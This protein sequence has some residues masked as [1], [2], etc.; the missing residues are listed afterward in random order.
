M[1][2]TV[3]IVGAGIVG[4]ALAQRLAAHDWDV[5]V[6]DQYEPASRRSASGGSSRLLR[7][8]H[9]GNE[10]DTRSAWAARTLWRELEDSL[11]QTLMIDTGAAFFLAE[12]D[13]WLGQS[14]GVLQE[15]DIPAQVMRRHEAKKLFPSLLMQDHEV[16]L[17]E[18]TATVLLA[19]K[20]VRALM[21]HAIAHGAQF[22]RGRASPVGSGAD[23]AGTRLSADRVIWAG[24][25][26][27]ARLFPELIDADVIEQDNFF[28][29]APPLWAAPAVPAWA[30]W[31]AG[32]SGSGDIGG[33]GVK[34][35]ADCD[36]PVVDLDAP[37][38]A[39]DRAQEEAARRYIA[40]RFPELSGAQLLG[41]EICHSVRVRRNVLSAVAT[42]GEVPI[43]SHP[44]A[45]GVWIIGDGSGH[46][47]KHGP[48]IACLVEHLIS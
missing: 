14:C 46:A 40:W 29:A 15:L 48:S 33:S 10:E 39:H 18:P 21:R 12:D 4:A 45:Q 25:A 9:G 28:F 27:N 41:V 24:G 3:L 22:L 43:A 38:A 7:A 11:D 44:D 19:R 16:V 17:Y 31:R 13:A 32:V 36:G 34:L 26:W 23:V 5:T 30:D 1:R 20:A 8:A 37:C 35:G 47:F 6:V 2:S 42:P